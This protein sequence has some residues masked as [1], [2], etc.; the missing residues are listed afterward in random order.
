MGATCSPCTTLNGGTIAGDNKSRHTGDHLFQ[1]FFYLV[2]LCKPNKDGEAEEAKITKKSVCRHAM[3]SQTFGTTPYVYVYMQKKKESDMESKNESL[4]CATETTE[5]E[6]RDTKKET[7]SRGDWDENGENS[8]F[9]SL[10]SQK[11]KKKRIRK[12][13]EKK[14]TKGSS[15]EGAN[16]KVKTTQAQR[17]S[18]PENNSNTAKTL[19]TNETVTTVAPKKEKTPPPPFINFKSEFISD[20]ENKYNNDQKEENEEEGET[21]EE[22]K[23]GI[24]S[25]QINKKFSNITINENNNEFDVNLSFQN[26]EEDN[27][28]SLQQQYSGSNSPFELDDKTPHLE[29][30]MSAHEPT[31]GIIYGDESILVMK[32]NY[33]FLNFLSFTVD[34]LIDTPKTIAQISF[35][36]V[37]FI[38]FSYS[39]IYFVTYLCAILIFVNI[40]KEKIH[41]S[42]YFFIFIIL[43]FVSSFLLSVIYLSSLKIMFFCARLLLCFV[44]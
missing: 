6:C 41:N 10:E 18:L 23:A 21:D 31:N 25:I 36:Y 35:I 5:S 37:T 12:G 9:L 44:F 22:E 2:F 11:S 19:D 3:K 16:A 26:N 42:N 28:L 20:K 27:D 39:Q 34:V 7:N 32:G 17:P 13:V 4:S 8:T 33:Y 30:Q 43:V 14:G 15:P 24:T 40:K 29:S 1:Y 38:M